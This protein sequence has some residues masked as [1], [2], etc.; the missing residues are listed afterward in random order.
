MIG[1]RRRGGLL[2]RFYTEVE[3]PTVWFSACPIRDLPRLNKFSFAVGVVR[4]S[5]C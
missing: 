4:N 3:K 1:S 5:A 2:P